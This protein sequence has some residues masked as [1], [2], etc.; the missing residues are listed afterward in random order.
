MGN[1]L[2]ETNEP[3]DYD[4]LFEGNESFD[5]GQYKEFGATIKKINTESDVGVLIEMDIDYRN[6]EVLEKLKTNDTSF[7][8]RYDAK[9]VI[10]HIGEGNASVLNAENEMVA[11]F[12]SA[13]KYRL[14]ISKECI[15]NI[16]KV[17]LKLKAKE[18]EISFLDLRDQYLIEIPLLV[19][20]NAADIVIYS[21]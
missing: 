1:K 13:A 18:T 20:L 8:P 15:A 17:T 9:N 16:S 3:V 19:V 10:I 11:V 21:K 7:M 12:L 6:A 4:S 5:E 14:L 2:S